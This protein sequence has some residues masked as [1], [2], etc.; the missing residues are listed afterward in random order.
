MLKSI[1]L[2]SSLLVCTACSSIV[3]Q[4]KNVTSRGTFKDF[5]GIC[6]SNPEA[7]KIFGNDAV[8]WERMDVSWGRIE[9]KRGKWNIKALQK[10]G[11]KILKFKQAGI[12][13]LPILDYTAGWAGVNKPNQTFELEGEKYE[14]I[15]QKDGSYIRRRY[16]MKTVAGKG[17]MEKVDSKLSARRVAGRWL[18]KEYQQDWNN[19]VEKTVKFLSA[20]PYNLKYFQIWNE[21][22]P[23]SSFWEGDMD[24]YMERIHIPASK[25][26][27]KLGKKVVFG[28]WP[29]CAKIST[30]EKLMD[31]HDAWKTFDAI[32]IHYFPLEAM[33]MVYRQ[34]QKRK[35][36]K[37]IWQTEIGFGTEPSL[38]GNLYPRALRWALDSNWDY[39]DKYKLFYFAHWSPH[40]K[41]AYGFGRTLLSG[42]NISIKG[43]SLI[44]LGKIFGDKP[45]SAF[46]KVTSE[47][48]LDFQLSE[49]QNSIE[50]FKAGNKVICAVHML[51]NNNAAIFIDRN[52]AG[53]TLHLNHGMPSVTLKFKDISSSQVEKVERISMIGEVEDISGNLKT[54]E[55][56][57]EFPV[58]IRDRR[59][60]KDKYVDMPENILPKVFYTVIYLKEN[61]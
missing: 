44:T 24:T 37:G 42:K 31:R 29:C 4:T 11:E 55:D 17:V 43:Q 50:A 51:S 32:D 54:T 18:S 13:V 40:D 57:I 30:F 56:G 7:T 25:I 6:H 5:S 34:L 16:Q 3:P 52:G 12:T 22:W 2:C 9:P 60:E 33:D 28:G 61:K 46:R 20:P 53:D 45:I 23:T 1:G 14:Y 8:G 10:Y 38:I 49:M 58:Y 48:Y 41:K 26:I 21:A 19:Y 59:V 15:R 47:P 36:D 35:L 39:A 27:H